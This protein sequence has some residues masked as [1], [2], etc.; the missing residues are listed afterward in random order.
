MSPQRATGDQKSS[1]T[2]AAL[3]VSSAASAARPATFA[4]LLARHPQLLDKQLLL[5][6]YT[7]DVLA[8][9]KAR[10]MWVA[11]D[12]IPIPGAPASAQ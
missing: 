8:S 7:P 9:S 3:A 11:P 6:H 10:A 2:R 4:E 12:L 5:K 1:A